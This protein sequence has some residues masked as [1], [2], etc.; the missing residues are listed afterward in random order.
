MV[1][2]PN[3]QDIIKY[4]GEAPQLE[5]ER[6]DEVRLDFLQDVTSKSIRVRKS[7]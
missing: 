4:Q 6:E 3:R 2:R 5:G 7:D 1:W